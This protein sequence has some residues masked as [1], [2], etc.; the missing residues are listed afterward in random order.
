MIR[1]KLPTTMTSTRAA[2]MPVPMAATGSA[3]AVRGVAGALVVVVLV[4][5][6]AGCEKPANADRVAVVGDRVIRLGDLEAAMER[7]GSGR[8]RGDMHAVLDEL[9]EDEIMVQQAREHGL[10]DDPE[11]R[12]MYRNFLIGKLKEKL[13]TPQLKATEVT[14]KEIRTYYKENRSRFVEPASIKIAVLYR[15]TSDRMSDE[16]REAIRAQLLEAKAMTEDL[17]RDG[18][19]FGAVAIR[20]SEDQ[21]TRY[22]GGL[23]GWIDPDR[24]GARLPDAVVD[25]AAALDRAGDISEPVATDQGMYLVR[26]AER[27]DAILTAIED[28]RDTIRQTLMKEKRAAVEKEFLENIHA[29]VPVRIFPEVMNENMEALLAKSKKSQI[30]QPPALP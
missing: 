1:L 17:N 9:I 10:E 13:L 28:V 6:F 30:S 14:D 16:K 27:K 8:L 26:L 21:T 22:K 24:G 12:R 3:S 5:V 18:L 7:A 11:F 19:D 29:S 23:V 4:L 2:T 15:K 25:A 20:H